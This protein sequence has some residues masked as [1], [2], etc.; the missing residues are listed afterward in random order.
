MLKVIRKYLPRP[1]KIEFR[2][3]QQPLNS[4]WSRFKTQGQPEF[5]NIKHVTRRGIYS[6][7]E[8]LV[9]YRSQLLPLGIHIGNI[10]STCG[11]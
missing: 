3:S 10:L 11:V 9:E 1:I 4:R 7:S 2:Y 6:N 5:R 8:I